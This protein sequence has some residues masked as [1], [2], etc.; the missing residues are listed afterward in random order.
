M[1]MEEN[2]LGDGSYRG[3]KQHIHRLKREEKN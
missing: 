1:L 2:N 3:G